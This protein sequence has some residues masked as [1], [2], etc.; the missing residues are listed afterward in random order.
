MNENTY[1]TGPIPQLCYHS[2]LQCILLQPFPFAV[3]F[4]IQTVYNELINGVCA[5]PRAV[6]ILPRS[7]VI[8]TNNPL[9]RR[10][11]RRRRKEHRRLGDVGGRAGED[12]PRKMRDTSTKGPTVTRTPNPL[13]PCMMIRL[14]PIIRPGRPKMTITTT[15]MM[16]TTMTSFIILSSTCCPTQNTILSY[17]DHSVPLS[18]DFFD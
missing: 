15:A 6:A 14:R 18:F 16:K 9:R 8:T 1:I 4:Y 5:S 13:W 11:Q 7:I 2:F 3:P 10:R 12:V 17:V